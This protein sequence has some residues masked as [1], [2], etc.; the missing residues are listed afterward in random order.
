MLYVSDHKQRSIMPLMFTVVSW[1]PEPL[2]EQV[3][4]PRAT[5]IN[6]GLSII[7]V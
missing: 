5:T 7:G 2:V 3:K 4:G 6:I 1:L